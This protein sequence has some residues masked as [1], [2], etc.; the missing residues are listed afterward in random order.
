MAPKKQTPP[1]ID[2]PL[3]KAYL[4]QFAGWSDEHPPGQSEPNSLRVMENVWIDRN[5]AVQVRPGLRHLTYTA[6]PDSSPSV[7]GLPGTAFNLPA[8]GSMEPFYL[9]DGS[10]AMLFAVR[11]SDGRV[12]FRALLLMNSTRTVAT[13]PE[14]GFTGY[15]QA[16]TPFTKGTGYVHYLQIDNTIIALSDNGEPARHFHAGAAK[17][18]SIPQEITSPSWAVADKPR[19][20]HPTAD[21]INATQVSVRRNLVRDPSMRLGADHW[22]P[23]TRTSVRSVPGGGMVVESLPLRTNLVNSPLHDVATTGAEGWYEGPGTSAGVSG[24]ALQIS[25]TGPGEVSVHGS[26]I[27]SG[28]VEKKRYS[29]GMLLGGGDLQTAHVSVEFLSCSGAP[30]GTA[31]LHPVWEAPP[32]PGAGIGQ[33]SSRQAS[34]APVGAVSAR[35]RIGGLASAAGQ[36][37]R[38]SDVVLCLEGEPVTPLHGGMGEHYSW[39]GEAN[40]SPSVHHP[41]VDAVVTSSRVQTDILKPYAAALSVKSASAVQASLGILTFS[42]SDAALGGTNETTATTGGTWQRVVNTT[43]SIGSNELFARVRLT[44]ESLARG[45]SVEVKEGLLEQAATAGTFFTGS[46]SHVDSTVVHRWEGAPHLSPSIRIQYDAPKPPLAAQT[47]TADTLVATGG[48]AGNPYKVGVFYTFE[49]EVGESAPSQITEIRTKRPWSNWVWVK[50]DSNGDPRGEA[51]DDPDQCADQLVVEIPRHAYDRAVLQGAKRW[52]LYGMSWSDQDPVPPTAERIA[53]KELYPDPFDSSTQA[54]FYENGGWISVTP[55]RTIGTESMT[56]PDAGSLENYSY[57]LRHRYGIAAGDRLIMVGDPTDPATISWSSNTPGRYTLF[58]L[59]T[60][61]GRKTLASGNLH[62]PHSAALWQNPQ[63]VDTLTVLCTSD[64]E[65]SVTYYMNPASV[66]SQ[67][68]TTSVMGFEETTNTPGSTSPYAVEVLNN[69]LYRPTDT[70]LMKSTASNYNISHKVM[71]EQVS[72]RWTGL[73]DKHEI[74]TAQLDNRLYCLVHNPDGDP[75]VG[76]CSGNEIWVLDISSEQ[77]HW[78]RFLIQAT[79]LK[80]V[81]VGGVTRMGVLHPGGIGYLEPGLRVDEAPDLEQAVL[82]APIPW[83]FETNL[84]GANRAH[85]AWAHLQQV[86]VTFGSFE[87]AVRWGVRGYSMHGEHID[88]QK[89]SEVHPPGDRSLPWSADDSL[90][91]RR[92]L[93]EWYFHA[94]G[95]GGTGSVQLVQYRYTPTTVNIGYEFGSVETFEYGSPVQ[96][97]SENGVPQP[98]SDAGRSWA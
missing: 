98:F 27:V 80:Q 32:P 57:P 54:H 3:S 60:G 10:R 89:T 45:Q 92:D 25:A 79:S 69:A 16:A 65:R 47:P 91:V 88:V 96:G 28:I 20:V 86:S 14:C 31:T 2:R 40:R 4:R 36:Y 24:S 55:R 67:Q 13:L 42:G 68:G 26:R 82:P 76:G 19:I 15:D 77:G 85:D 11:E 97:Y 41:P 34:P 50:P 21:W 87:G 17:S 83:K 48:P 53:T 37:I 56:L 44:L 71:T 75:L 52:H 72:R 23:G 49:N 95:L 94:E 43:N 74:V 51:T 18:C 84:Q 29:I 66:Q 78:S 70:A 73:L 62:L 61:G 64:T 90:L 8:V 63:S 22:R 35:L 39:T 59:T 46:S 81:V 38:I 9:N 12:G 33:W 58:S 5:G 6:S 30:V 7:D 93:K 1:P